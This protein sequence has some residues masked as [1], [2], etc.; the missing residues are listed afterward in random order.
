M[1]NLDIIFLEIKEILEKQSENLFETQQYIG[2]QSKQE[3]PGFH[4]YGNK[5]VSLF[6]KKPQKT[7]VA[8]V[9]KQKNYVSFY[10][11]PVY[12]HPDDFN[13]INPD[14]KKFLKGKSCFNIN[15]TNPEILKEIQVLLIRGI[16]KYKEIEWI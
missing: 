16:E 15:K 5:D 7:Y 4:L 12:S 6:G 11:S 9:I 14:L 10:F 3:K 2:S 1:D 8:G 13:D